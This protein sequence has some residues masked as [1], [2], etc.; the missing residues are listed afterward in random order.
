V[1]LWL[2]KFHRLQSITILGVFGIV[3]LIA[4]DVTAR[5]IGG[6]MIAWA[7]LLLI[8]W[9]KRVFFLFSGRDLED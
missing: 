2:R 4:G 8:L 3:L 1:L 6:V 9:R 7:L 5:V